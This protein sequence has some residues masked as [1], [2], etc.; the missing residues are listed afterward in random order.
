MALLALLGVANELLVVVAQLILLLEEVV[1]DLLLASVD[2]DR[3]VGRRVLERTSELLLVDPLARTD[4]VS[5]GCDASDDE[6]NS[7][8]NDAG[9]SGRRRA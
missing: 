8:I 7:V 6:R 2:A 5:D 3:D 4:R 9:G 1:L